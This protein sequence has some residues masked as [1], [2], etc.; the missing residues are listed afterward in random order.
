M[1]GEKKRTGKIMRSKGRKGRKERQREGRREGETVGRRK[2][3][4]R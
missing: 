3:T 2:S 4:S 1:G